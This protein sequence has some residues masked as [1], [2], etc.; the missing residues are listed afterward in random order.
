MSIVSSSVSTDDANHRVRL[1]QKDVHKSPR[2]NST[3]DEGAV[4]CRHATMLTSE[5]IGSRRF[6]VVD[7]TMGL[8]LPPRSDPLLSLTRPRAG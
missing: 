3:S 5:C 4:S 8:V 6:V 2:D 1:L 7:F